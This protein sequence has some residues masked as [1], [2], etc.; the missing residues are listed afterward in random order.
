[1][2]D[3]T[4]CRGR[5]PEIEKLLLKY[6]LTITPVNDDAPIPGS[7]WGES[8]AGLINN[9]LYIRDDTPLHSLFHEACHYI[10]M[11]SDRRAQLH[12]DA[13]GDY[14][15]ENGVCYLQIILSDELAGFSADRMMRDMDRWG[16]TFRLGSAR[17]WFEEDAEDARQ[18]LLKAGII[19]CLNNPTW[20]LRS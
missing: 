15:E 5:V 17:A 13:G 12:T 14:D 19:D 9:R 6:A 20:K 10:C 11:E 1:M 4:H 16:Y 18:W 3:V 7:Y 8:E 2:P